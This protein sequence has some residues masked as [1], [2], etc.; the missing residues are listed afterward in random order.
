[1]SARVCMLVCHVTTPSTSSTPAFGGITTEL[2]S[3]WYM[4]LSKL[5][6][7]LPLEIH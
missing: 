5:I 2:E 3:E 6:D 4:G 7:S 1:M